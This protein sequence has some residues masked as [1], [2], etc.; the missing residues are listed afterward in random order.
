MRTGRTTIR[1]A[2]GSL[3]VLGML[4]SAV[5][6]Q[7]PRVLS[8]ELA[9]R[10]GLHRNFVLQ[11]EMDGAIDELKRVTI[12]GDLLLAQSERGV[13]H[14]VDA[15][16]GATRWVLRLPER[17]HPTSAAGANGAYCAVANGF[18][19][20]VLNR[21]SGE[22]VWQRKLPYMPG[23]GPALSETRVYVP[24]ANGAMLSLDLNEPELTPAQFASNG[25]IEHQPIVANRAICWGSTAGLVYGM[26]RDQTE[27]SFQLRT[28]EPVTTRLGAAGDAVF[29]GSRD[30]FVYCLDDRT[31]LERWRFPVGEAINDQPLAVEDSVY[32]VP[33]LGGIY[34]IDI[35]SGLQ[36]WW[37]PEA[38]RC[39]AISAD[40]VYAVD[41]LGRLLILNKATGGQ[42]ARAPTGRWM[43]SV[44]ND[45]SDRIYLGTPQGVLI[46]LRE[47]AQPQP[48]RYNQPVDAEAASELPAVDPAN[49]DDEDQNTDF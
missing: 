46:C 25:R 31:G 34:R 41:R 23:A 7:S 17:D 47:Q 10:Y 48:L 38:Q 30:G 3:L 12:Y 36:T 20:F 35:E 27:I 39:L 14:A 33:E 43:F 15:E 1:A 44:E 13:V 45:Q 26:L 40:R 5:V 4:N 22:V 49:P 42:V 29:G 32:V 28:G 11:V 16:T 18:E 19:L 9:A 2:T 6:A 21:L 24:C 37:A 8:A